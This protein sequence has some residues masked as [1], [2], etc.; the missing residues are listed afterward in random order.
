MKPCGEGYPD[1]LP[2]EQWS[3]KDPPS[4]NRPNGHTGDHFMADAKT[5]KRLFTWPNK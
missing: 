2:K 1:I 3:K 5:F 4:C